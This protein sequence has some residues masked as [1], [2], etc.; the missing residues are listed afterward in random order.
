MPHTEMVDHFLESVQQE[1]SKNI[2]LV[3]Q[4]KKTRGYEVKIS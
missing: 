1:K 3:F 4:E 2:G